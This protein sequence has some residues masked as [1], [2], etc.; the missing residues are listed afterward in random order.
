MANLVIDGGA[1]GLWVGR[2]TWGL[3]VKGGRNGAL[4]LD[5]EVVGQFVKLIGTD[6]R[7]YKGC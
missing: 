6:T 2:I 1:N 5:H 3:V 7:L 4:N